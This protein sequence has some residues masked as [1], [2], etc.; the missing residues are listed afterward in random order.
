[1]IAFRSP[2]SLYKPAGP[3][4]GELIHTGTLEEE[5]EEDDDEFCGGDGGGAAAGGL[6]T[7]YCR[8]RLYKRVTKRKREFLFLRK[9]KTEAVGGVYRW[10]AHLSGGHDESAKR[11]KGGKRCKEFLH[12]NV[13]TL[14]RGGLN[15]SVIEIERIR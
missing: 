11:G 12:P 6:S 15:I 5:E 4:P 3:C 2:R 10:T 13:T 8:V 7:V 9:K 14:R 1:M